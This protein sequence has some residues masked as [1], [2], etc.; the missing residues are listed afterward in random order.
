MLRSLGTRDRARLGAALL[1]VA[2]VTLL[3]LNV[4]RVQAAGEGPA[5]ALVASLPE[6]MDA[7]G[8]RNFLGCGFAVGMIVGGAL[9]LGAHPLGGATAISLGLHLALFT[10]T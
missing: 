1:L 9:A 2:L 10:C 8:G 6:A 5:A 3:V 4:P 7:D